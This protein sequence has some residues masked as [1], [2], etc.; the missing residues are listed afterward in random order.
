MSAE[1]LETLT[2]ATSAITR[3]T[4]ALMRMLKPSGAH[5]STVL[6]FSLLNVMGLVDKFVVNATDRAMK[7]SYV[8]CA[9]KLSSKDQ[10]ITSELK[11]EQNA[12]YADSSN[13]M[14]ATQ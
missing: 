3:T 11:S 10:R 9:L 13:K 12:R 14:L 1:K 8:D 4:K 7:N 2:I 5:P 6:A